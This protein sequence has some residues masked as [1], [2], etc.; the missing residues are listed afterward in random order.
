MSTPALKK[1]Y[2]EKVVPELQKTRGYKNIHDVPKIEKIVLN[3]GVKA[4]EGKEVVDDA[5]NELTRI[6][7]QRAV[8]T[9]ARLSISNFKLRQGQP[10]GAKVTLRG[11]NMWEFLYRLVYVALPAIRDFRGVPAKLD[12]QGNYMLGINDHTIFPEINVD[13]VKRQLG[14][15]VCIVTTAATD[16]EGRELLR[17]LG[18]PFIKPTKK[19]EGEQSEPA[20]ADAAAAAAL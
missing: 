3:T 2:Q 16:E 13:Q 4:S 14:F 11:A 15:D 12:G 20:G 5:A 9:K 8:Q 1:I 6:S 19:T 7:G 17:L 18:M 10:I